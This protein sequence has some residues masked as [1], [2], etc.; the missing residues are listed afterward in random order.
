VSAPESAQSSP[1]P[2][3]SSWWE[4]WKNLGLLACTVLGL[5]L[6]F[7]TMF[8]VADVLPSFTDDLRRMIALVG[9]AAAAIY[10]MARL[11][12]RNR[13]GKPIIPGWWRRYGR[14]IGAAWIAGALAVIAGCSP[15][16]HAE[17]A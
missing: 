3:P 4:P 9:L 2:E 12:W 6:S 15:S 16:D 7:A 1:P 10:L 5:V 14:W 17:S 8:W 11:E 13:A